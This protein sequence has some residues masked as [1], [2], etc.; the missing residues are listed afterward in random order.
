MATDL[1]SWAAKF[2]SL[3]D[4]DKAIDAMARYYTCS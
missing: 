2:K 1:K 4:S 3:S